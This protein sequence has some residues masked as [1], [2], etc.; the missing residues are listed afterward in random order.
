MARLPYL[1]QEDLSEENKRLLQRPANLFRLLVHS[2]EA[3]RNFSRLGG[4]IRSGSTLDARLREMAILQVGYLTDAEYEWTHHIEIGR[5]FGVTDD[6]VR[7]IVTETEGG[8]SALAQLDRLVL[9]AAREMTEGL[10][11]SDE[12]FEGLRA[13]LSN[14]H[15]V[16]LFMTVAYYNLVVRV[17]HSLEVDLEDEYQHILKEFPLDV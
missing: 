15:I 16:D 12:A 1:N 10:K 5:G 3:F 17:L 13:H 9:R 6:D 7:A 4:W 8:G 14:E 11:V 2:P